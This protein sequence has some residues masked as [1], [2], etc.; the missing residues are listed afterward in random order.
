MWVAFNN[1]S[2]YLGHYWTFAE[3]SQNVFSFFNKS[4]DRYLESR[5]IQN[6]TQSKSPQVELNSSKSDVSPHTSDN[7]PASSAT[8]D[9]GYESLTSE[10]DSSSVSTTQEFSAETKSADG[11]RV[12]N[13]KSTATKKRPSD[14]SI[15]FILGHKKSR[16]SKDST[17]T[18]C[19][20][21]S[22]NDHE[23]VNM[24]TFSQRRLC[25]EIPIMRPEN[26]LYHHSVV[27][28]DH[29]MKIT[30]LQHKTCF[31][32][33]QLH[34]IPMTR[35][36]DASRRHRQI[37]TTIDQ[38]SPPARTGLTFADPAHITSSCDFAIKR[39]DDEAKRYSYH[40]LLNRLNNFGN[41][42][43]QQLD[44]NLAIRG[45]RFSNSLSQYPNAGLPLPARMYSNRCIPI[46]LPFQC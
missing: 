25:E 8:P 46:Y 37:L 5:I 2:A 30:S 39:L 22:E 12:G 19:T 15:D 44:R 11:E 42:P 16:V 35:E 29:E 41:M 24:P 43:I 20:L 13:C 3:G 32:D 1:V 34:H 40:N 21:N 7:N 36:C 14:F 33:F 23:C 45:L 26:P 17:T 38:E 4:D 10:S 27:R 9:N 6:K 31:N 28:T 18:I